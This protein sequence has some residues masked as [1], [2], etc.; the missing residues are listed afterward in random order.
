MPRKSIAPWSERVNEGLIDQPI[1]SEIL[2]SQSL[3]PTVNTGTIDRDGQWKGIVTSDKA[4]FISDTATGIANGG[5]VLFPNT[6]DADFIDMTGFNDGQIA[7]KPTNAG[8]YAISAVM[9]PATHQFAN[10]SPVNS[11]AVLRGAGWAYDTDPDL[12][13]LFLDS[14]EAL[15][16]NVW[17]IFMIKRSLSNQKLLQFKVTNDSGG[18]SDIDFAYLRVV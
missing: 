15:T 16:A 14:A 8:N 4:F 9:G 3:R 12:E 10:L 17:N 7:I 18:N 1:D 13:N 6:A 5:D 2:A 11:A